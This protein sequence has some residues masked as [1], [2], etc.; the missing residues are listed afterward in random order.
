MK[1]ILILCVSLKGSSDR[2]DRILKQINNLKQNLKNIEIDFNFFDAVLGKKLPPEYLTFLNLSRE[3]AGKCKHHLGPSELG[4]FLSH[5]ILWQRLA[6]GDYS[7]YDRVIII[8]DD[9]QLNA[10]QIEQKILSLITTNPA[11]AFLGGHSEPS[12]RRIRGYISDDQLYFQMT[13]PKDLYTATYA[14]SL[15]AD[16]AQ[17]FINKQVKALSFIDDWK[18]LLAGAITTPY[19]FCFEHDDELESSIADDRKQFMKKPNRFMKNFNKMKNDLISR[20]ISLFIFKKII[21]LSIFLKK[22]E[23][24]KNNDHTD[25]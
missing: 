10:D 1:S 16:T 11:F 17:D 21:R 23:I 18:Y 9:V 7:A 5:M 13:G 12:R 4:C 19:Y 22:Q 25:I 24:K 20:L 6:Q 3:F 8:E 15:T 14:Y 2:Q